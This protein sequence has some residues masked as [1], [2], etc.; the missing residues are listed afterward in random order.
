[1]SMIMEKAHA[2]A[3]ALKES[4]ELTNL[5][6][7]EAEMARDPGAQEILT[8][9]HQIRQKLEQKRA[10]GAELTDAEQ[11]SMAEVEKKMQ[12]NPIISAH[13]EAQKE[14]NSI[15]QGVNFILTKALSGEVANTCGPGCGGSCC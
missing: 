13:L 6:N 15:L 4:E 11:A 7:T 12:S 9:Y 10:S 8:E 1:M 3:D 14:F 2:L 5:R